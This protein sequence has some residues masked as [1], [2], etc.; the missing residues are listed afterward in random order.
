MKKFN[1]LIINPHSIDITTG[2]EDSECEITYTDL[3]VKLKY[4]LEMSEYC[5][6][7]REKDTSPAFASALCQKCIENKCRF[8]DICVGLHEMNRED[9]KD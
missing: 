5:K 1:N 3:W 9:H 7:I 8:I 6:G 2:D 4:T